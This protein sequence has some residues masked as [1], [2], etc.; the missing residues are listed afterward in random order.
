M[1]GVELETITESTTI[2]SFTRDLA[3][4]AKVFAD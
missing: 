4:N 3:L 2:D 1:T